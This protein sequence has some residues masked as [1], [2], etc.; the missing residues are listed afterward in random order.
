MARRKWRIVRPWAFKC[1]GHHGERAKCSP[2]DHGRSAQRTARR[3]ST[4]GYQRGCISSPRTTL[5]DAHDLA[6]SSDAVV[7]HEVVV[8]PILLLCTERQWIGMMGYSARWVGVGGRS[9]SIPMRGRA[10]LNARVDVYARVVAV[11][12][13]GEIYCAHAHMGLRMCVCVCVCVCVCLSVCV[14][15]CVCV[16]ARARLYESMVWSCVHARVR[17]YRDC[18]DRLGSENA[19]DNRA[20]R[21]KLARSH[22]HLRKSV[23]G[24]ERA[25]CVNGA[26]CS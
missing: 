22:A 4:K 1:R 13:D 5:T 21:S 26:E 25:V 18:L 10:E 16:R 2:C 17:S 3:T 24:H 11:M 7:K 20:H 14:C 23:V 8:R 19:P 12:T 6:E 15:V 9:V